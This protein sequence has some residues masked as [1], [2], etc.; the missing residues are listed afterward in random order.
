MS[1]V[2]KEGNLARLLQTRLQGCRVT[3]EELIKIRLAMSGSPNGDEEE[4]KIVKSTVGMD[5]YMM[6]IHILSK[7]GK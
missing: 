2:Q 6:H 5:T 7:G 3:E 1:P 4:K